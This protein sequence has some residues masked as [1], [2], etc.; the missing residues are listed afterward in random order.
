M[1]NLPNISLAIR[2]ERDTPGQWSA[3]NLHQKRYLQESRYME[4]TYCMGQDETFNSESW[5]N[6]RAWGSPESMH[7]IEGP[8]VTAQ[9]RSN[10]EWMCIVDT[11]IATSRTNGKPSTGKPFPPG[12]NSDKQSLFWS[13][14][15]QM[16][17]QYMEKTRNFNFLSLNIYSLRL[18]IYRHHLPRLANP[19]SGL[20]L[21]ISPAFELFFGSWSCSIAVHTFL[22]TSVFVHICFCVCHSMASRSVC[23]TKLCGTVAEKYW[24]SDCGSLSIYTFCPLHNRKTRI[25]KMSPP[26]IYMRTHAYT[27]THTHRHTHEHVHTHIHTRYLK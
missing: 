9:S 20:Q 11:G 10:P 7:R 13:K 12:S 18:L 24:F 22:V 5:A 26:L 16:V 17:G 2:Y 21:I 15:L 6:V 25:G 19:P 3:C 23:R 4:T 1:S 27:Y 8:L 14:Y